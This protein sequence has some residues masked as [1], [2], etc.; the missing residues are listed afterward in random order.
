MSVPA[1][2]LPAI[3]RRVHTQAR[4]L[5]L[6]LRRSEVWL[7]CPPRVAEA[8]IQRFLTQS[9]PWLDQAWQA[10]LDGL[11][12]AE[13]TDILHVAMLGQTWQIMPDLQCEQAYT[14]S[15]RLYVPQQDWPQHVKDWIKQHAQIHLPHRLQQLSQQH[16]FDYGRCTVRQVVSR[17]GSCSAQ[18]NISLNAALLLL[19]I[20]LV[21]YVLLHEL[22]HTRQMNHSAAFWA[23]MT[24]VCADWPIRRQAL[25]TTKLP[26]WWGA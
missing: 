2:P 17:W 8:A 16:G 7:T 15:E 11:P 6:T 10:Y 24:A 12:V 4:R 25:K 26:R 1:P 18:K 22:C 21:D 13:L 5:K 14:D 23:E 3:K 9:Q 20:E 19:P